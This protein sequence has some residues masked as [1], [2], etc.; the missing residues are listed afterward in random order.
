MKNF[1]RRIVA[2][3]T[4]IAASM[5]ICSC[6]DH[7]RS[8]KSESQ[9]GYTQEKDSAIIVS[10]I[11]GY[12]Y[13]TFESTA[14]IKVYQDQ[15]LMQEETKVVFVSMTPEMIERVGKVALSKSK[16]GRITI[17]DL[18]QEYSTNYD[19]YSRQANTGEA[20]PQPPSERMT[21]PEDIPLDKKLQPVDTTY[22]VS[23]DGT[24]TRTIK[25]RYK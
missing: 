1:I 12:V 16:N 24:V 4:I 14:D 7:N 5:T 17:H 18:V 11:D 22:E 19:V 15:Y 21:P 3:F 23:E 9:L 13:P 6:H 25:Y 20:K 2:V 10:V 8:T